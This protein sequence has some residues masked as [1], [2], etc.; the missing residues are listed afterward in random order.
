MSLLVPQGR[1]YHALSGV[2]WLTVRRFPGAASCGSR[3]ALTSEVVRQCGLGAL[4]AEPLSDP[5]GSKRGL[6][7]RPGVGVFVEDICPQL[8]QPRID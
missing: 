3:H 4:F 7:I 1:G 2:A 6:V 8:R 5:S